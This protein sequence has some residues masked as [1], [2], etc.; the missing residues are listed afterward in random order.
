MTSSITRRLV[1]SAALPAGFDRLIDWN[2]F[3][4]AA[5][6]LEALSAGAIDCGGWMG[7]G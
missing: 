2:I 1:L 5:P 6:L 4:A 7:R 3:G